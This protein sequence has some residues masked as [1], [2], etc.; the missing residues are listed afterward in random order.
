MSLNI[1]KVKKLDP[2]AIIPTKAHSTDACMDLYAIEPVVF[3]PGE[4][5]YVR[6]G[7]AFEIPEGY[8]IE[9][10]PRSGLASKQQ[11]IILNSP[12]II[13]SDYR[14]EVM[15]FMK[16][17]KDTNSV[18]INKGD[19]YAQ[20]SL[21]KIIDFDFEEVDELTGTERGTGGFGSSGK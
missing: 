12:A 20:M 9:V 21:K 3:R 11:L 17:L 10:K 5:K 14:G 2:Y 16:N 8:Y 18:V 6:S 13:D 7:L 15:I 4:V 19:R 1:V